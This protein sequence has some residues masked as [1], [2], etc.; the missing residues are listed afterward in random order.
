MTRLN[1]IC[2]DVSVSDSRRVECFRR[3][4]MNGVWWG[5]QHRAASLYSLFFLCTALL[6]GL[7]LFAV[8]AAAQDGPPPGTPAKGSNPD[9]PAGNPDLI[10]IP[11]E[12]CTVTE[13]ASVTLEDDE[14][15]TPARFVDG[16]KGIEITA[17]ESQIRIEGPNDV[18]IGDSA[19]FP[20][21]NDTSFST[22][23]NYTVVST[24]GI[25]C[26][27]TGTP[28]NE[29]ARDAAV[30]QY[31]GDT[32][33]TKTIPKK[34]VPAT[35]GLP[36]LSLAVVGLALVGVGLSMIRVIVHR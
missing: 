33:I 30:D 15:E 6:F 26:R 1:Q 16:Q 31:R 3:N 10:T 7:G 27:G 20:D 4:N 29:P 9:N 34:T 23:G 32:I 12:N 2:R 28:P 21:P 19:T 11:A 14:G 13:G 8:P 18:F 36:L 35:G 25:A 24:T 5:M 22:N 17:T